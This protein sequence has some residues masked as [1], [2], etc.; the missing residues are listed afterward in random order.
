LEFDLALDGLMRSYAVRMEI[1]RAMVAFYDRDGSSRYD[2]AFENAKRLDRPREMLQD[3]ANEDVVKRF[4]L[5]WHIEDV[6]LL[7]AHIL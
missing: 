5:I 2:H 7:K 4:Q 3:K 1:G 6:S